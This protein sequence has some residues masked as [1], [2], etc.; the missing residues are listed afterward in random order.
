M[1]LNTEMKANITYDMYA[2]AHNFIQK[3]THNSLILVCFS[4]NTYPY[5]NKPQK[6][7]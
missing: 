7:L 1:K 6:P 2:Y 4:E 3:S 5:M